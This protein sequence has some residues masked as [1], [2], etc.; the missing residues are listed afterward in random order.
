M[1]VPTSAGLEETCVYS[2]FRKQNHLLQTPTVCLYIY[3][4]KHI[5]PLYRCAFTWYETQQPSPLSLARHLQ[6]QRNKQSHDYSSMDQSIK[7]HLWKYIMHNKC[8]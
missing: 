3:V 7:H 5:Y 4:N 8:S 2:D 6:A 1:Q